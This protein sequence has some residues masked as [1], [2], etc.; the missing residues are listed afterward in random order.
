MKA[1]VSSRKIK[2]IS[3]EKLKTRG[4]LETLEKI[5]SETACIVDIC[6]LTSLQ[7][8]H[9]IVV[10]VDSMSAVLQHIKTQSQPCES[11]LKVEECDLSVGIG[12]Q[13]FNNVLMFPSLVTLVVRR[14]NMGGCFPYYQQWTCYFL[15]FII[16][17]LKEKNF[18]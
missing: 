15:T 4:E 1:F 13:V 2:V 16:A 11:H 10:D 8:L 5:H 6:K 7:K 17:C 18:M 9:V 12:R 3:G 14:C